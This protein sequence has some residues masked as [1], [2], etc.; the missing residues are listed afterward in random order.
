MSL[1]KIRTNDAIHGL[2]FLY[3]VLTMCF[4]NSLPFRLISIAI[5]LIMA[6][7][8]AL[9]LMH[10][11]KISLLSVSFVYFVFV[12]FA[13]LSVFWC[14]SIDRA[15]DVCYELL[16]GLL[17]IVVID[18]SVDNHNE[19]KKYINSFLY[20]VVIM[21][22]LLLI[23]CGFDI[24][25]I[26]YSG[27]GIIGL[28]KN[29]FSQICSFSIVI[30]FC[31]CKQNFKKR[32]IL[33]ILLFLLI[34]IGSGSR[35]ALLSAGL[36]LLVMYGFF[37]RKNVKKFL[38]YIILSTAIL[39]VAIVYL[40]FTKQELFLR[41]VNGILA[42]LGNNSAVSDESATIRMALIERGFELFGEHPILGVG[43]NNFCHF[44]GDINIYGGY[45]YAHNNYI[46][47]LSDFGILGFAIYHT[48]YIL[49][50]Y[51]L[52]KNSKPQND[53]FVAALGFSLII[54]MLVNDIASVSYY[55]KMYIF[56]FLLA[57]KM[58]TVG[59]KDNENN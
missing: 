58:I 3:L 4:A 2:Y 24:T 33:F 39:I 7:L 52:S 11:R 29:Y 55:L 34:I 44:S 18:N 5:L 48:I 28:D 12:L 50:F 17:F 25:K 57:Y 8:T 16:T 45:M 15:T 10:T 51:R 31:H 41:I 36:G 46:E 40:Y 1:T 23:G 9:K 42:F 53:K 19:L 56:M 54:L 47:V 38:K 59:V 27:T 22:I 26:R 32:Y 21:C 14:Y 49:F 30:T 35:K 6:G 37:Y 20:V 43:L 13:I